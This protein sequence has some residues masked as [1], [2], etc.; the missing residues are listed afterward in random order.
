MKILL[1]SL[2]CSIAIAGIG[3]AE[4]E[5]PLDILDAPKAVQK[6]IHL[7]ILLLP[8]G[9]Q[10]DELSIEDESENTIYEVEIEVPGGIEYEIEMNDQGEI[11]EIEMEYED[12]ENETSESDK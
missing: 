6:T 2:L 7:F 4:D 1:I 8:E 3:N 10:L 12:D 11:L 5:E 9:A